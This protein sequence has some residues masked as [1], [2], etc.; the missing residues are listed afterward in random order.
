[1]I[2]RKRQVGGAG[3][4]DRLAVV[5]RLR[6]GELFEMASMRSAMRLRTRA[7]STTLVRPQASFAACAASSAA[8]TSCASERAILQTTW[9]VTG[10]ML[11]KYCPDLGAT[12]LPPIKLS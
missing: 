2:D 1:M 3:F 11:S 9:P 5:P 7:R 4:A 10:E 8:S 12:H 6:N